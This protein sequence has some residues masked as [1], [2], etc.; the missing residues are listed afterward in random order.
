MRNFIALL[1]SLFGIVLL[2]AY[3]LSPSRPESAI[4]V[5]AGDTAFGESYKI[6]PEPESLSGDDRYLPSMKY[7]L[8][9][10]GGASQVLLNLE[11][12][13]T[14]PNDSSPDGKTYIHWSCPDRSIAALKASGVTA[15]GLAN[16]HTMDYGGRGLVKTLLTLEKADIAWGGAGP[17]LDIAEAPLLWDIQVGKRNVTVAVFFGFQYRKSYDE[18]YDFYASD[19]TVGVNP[20]DPARLKTLIRELRAESPEVYVIVFPH[21]GKNYKWRSEKQAGLAHELVEAGADLVIGHGAHHLQQIEFYRGKCILYG[22]GNFV[23]HSR[24]R[25]DRE[26]VLPFGLVARLEMNDTEEDLE[27]TLRLYPIQS[28]NRVTDFRSRPVTQDEFEELKNMLRKHIKNEDTL[29]RITPGRDGLGHYL[30]IALP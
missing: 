6:S 23:F 14:L 10:T 2:V 8:L 25:F 21:W 26:K 5:F 1:A 27:K 29:S 18:K 11:T 7:L 15:V 9:L 22:L 13:L 17:R 12:P 4:L 30:E 28:N 24:G 20:L 19:K 16:N 3:A